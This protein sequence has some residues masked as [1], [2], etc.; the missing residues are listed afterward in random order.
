MNKTIQLFSLA[1]LSLLA[2]N[3]CLAAKVKAE[4][5]VSL[6]HDVKVWVQ[7]TAL[8]AAPFFLDAAVHQLFLSNTSFADYQKNNV[9]DSRT[10]KFLG[11]RRNSY[12]HA[13]ITGAFAAYLWPKAN[14]IS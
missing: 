1:A 5:E 13:L 4:V 7:R 14:K 2:I 8:Y 10:P 11:I 9:T 3:N 12:S 6:S